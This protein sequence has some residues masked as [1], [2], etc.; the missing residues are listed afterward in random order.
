M[1][2]PLIDVSIMLSGPG[3]QKLELLSSIEPTEGESAAAA[4]G[5]C[6]AATV[7]SLYMSFLHD[8]HYDPAGTTP[9]AAEADQ[10]ATICSQVSAMCG[11]NDGSDAAA[12][13]PH[14]IIDTSCRLAASAYA[15]LSLASRVKVAHYSALTISIDE[16]D[17]HHGSSTTAAA[18]RARYLQ[19]LAL[20]SFKLCDPEGYAKCY[21]GRG[22][23]HPRL[24]LMIRFLRSEQSPFYGTH[25]RRHAGLVKS[26]LDYVEATLVEADLDAGPTP[27]DLAGP[28][29]AHMR[30]A[31]AF[32]RH[33]S[34]IAEA[35]AHFIFM[36]CCNGSK[37]RGQEQCHP[38][39]DGDDDDD[40][41]RLYSALYAVIPELV[42]SIQGIN[43][44]LS[45]HK[46]LQDGE[47]SR[48][49]IAVDARIHGVSLHDALA[50]YARYMVGSRSRIL[51]LLHHL[52]AP[53]MRATVHRFLQG[54]LAF[55]VG[56]SRYRLHQLLP[57]AW[58]NKE[59]C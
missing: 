19:D 8:M 54:Y 16:H 37:S 7:R 2:S 43:D 10:T 42:C 59:T 29:S 21:P 51:S 17:H 15:H 27:V 41:A 28:A 14:Y 5:T 38:E 57:P 34:G 46:E 56:H 40:E 11:I 36:D 47:T 24:E 6:A 48:A 33:K 18:A 4:N 32:W 9:S 3:D 13:V 30:L 1:G 31:P 55:H 52:A 25:L 44:V 20:F 45:L 50:A 39:D 53:D 58:Y 49:T 12:G 23:L 26:T 22:P 35:Y